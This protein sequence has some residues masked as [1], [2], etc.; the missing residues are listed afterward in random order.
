[1]ASK[2]I[3]ITV[4]PGVV[5]NGTQYQVQG[6]WFDSNLVR[7]VEG[8]L[9]PMGGWQRFATIA[10]G[11]CRALHAWMTNSATP[12]LAIG[13][14]QKLYVGT[15]SSTL[16]DI[17][18]ASFV[19]GADDAYKQQGYGGGAYGAGAYGTAR[20]GGYLLPTIWHLDNFGEWLVACSPSDG[21]IFEWKDDYATPTHAAVVSNAPLNCAGVIVTE[22]RH[23]MAFGA[24]GNPRLVS[25]SGKEQDTVWTPASTN[26][27]GSFECA[28]VGRFVKAVK[29]NKQILVLYTTDAFGLTYIGQPYI[30]GRE[31]VGTDC[32]PLGSAA[33]AVVGG[34]AAW[35]GQQGFWIFDGSSV[36]PLP[37]DLQDFV[38][39]NINRAQLSKTVCAKNGLFKEISWFIP[40]GDSLEP[41]TQ[42]TWNYGEKW[43]SKN[44]IGRTAWVDQGVFDSPIAAD[45]SNVLFRHEQD[46]LADG[47]SMFQDMYVESG[48][49]ETPYGDYIIGINQILPDEGTPGDLTVTIKTRFTPEGQEY[50]YGPYSARSDGYMDTRAS[51]RQV[52]LRFQPTRDADWRM[53]TFRMAIDQRGK[54]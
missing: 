10:S 29:V 38:F 34:F 6:R 36:Q 21:R 25:W 45:S 32:G 5:R 11:K 30:F 27:A 1:M 47:A 46:N 12:Y 54:R 50:V 35:I 17:T 24:G 9:R 31:R 41:D 8:V 19:V 22:Q 49:I 52:V 13:T 3:P 42:I 18:P 15:G 44:A 14:S 48:A 51:G 43:W 2:L 26:E 28:T 53:G 23:I 20:D 33:V 7:W 39:K 16:K 4:P 40:T 37:C